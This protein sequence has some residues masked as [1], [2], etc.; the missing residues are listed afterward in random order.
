MPENGGRSRHAS[1][2]ETSQNT[3]TEAL[4]RL[5]AKPLRPADCR[6]GRSVQNTNQRFAGRKTTVLRKP[7]SIRHLVHIDRVV[8]CRHGIDYQPLVGQ[9]RVQLLLLIRGRSKGLGFIAMEQERRPTNRDLTT[10]RS[11][12]RTPPSKGKKNDRLR[13]DHHSGGE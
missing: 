8:S 13:E 11:N 12:L 4:Q 2:L 7:G 1:G 5:S 3:P 6:S 10:Q 9:K